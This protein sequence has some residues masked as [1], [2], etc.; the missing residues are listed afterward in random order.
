MR[1]KSQIGHL[2][3]RKGIYQNQKFTL[4][5]RNISAEKVT[6]FWQTKRISNHK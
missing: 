6:N 3:C 2:F 4:L 1:E 5:S